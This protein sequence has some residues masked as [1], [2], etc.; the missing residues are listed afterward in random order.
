MGKALDAVRETIREAEEEHGMPCTDIGLEPEL[1]DAL[2]AECAPRLPSDVL[3]I[4]V[5]RADELAREKEPRDGTV[6]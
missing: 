2:K 1:Y 5:W 4:P 3:G 6:H